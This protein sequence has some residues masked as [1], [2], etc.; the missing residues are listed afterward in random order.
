MAQDYFLSLENISKTFPG[1][2]AL[3][4]VQLHIRPGEVHALLGENG[5]GKST[6][7]K[8]M[9]GVYKPDEGGRMEICGEPV[10]FNDINES[11]QKGVSVIYQD[12]CL[13]PNLTVAEN[14]CIGKDISRKGWIQWKEYDQMAKETLKRLN[15]EIPIH[16]KLGN[17]SIARQ[18]LVAIARAIAFE[19]R[20]IVMD[21]P[22]ASLS[23]SEVE[24]LFEIIRKL[25]KDGISVLFI[26][27]KLDEVMAISDRMTVLR[28]G[29]FVG[30]K[31]V[32]EV[33][34]QEIIHMM[35]GRNIEYIKLNE[36]SNATERVV[37]EVS[38]ISKKGHFKDISFS[39][40]EGEILG[41]T[42]LVG[43]GRTEV[44]KSL[45]GLLPPDEGKIWLDGNLVQ[46]KGT[47]DAKRHG[48]S[49]V[50]EDRQTE[51][52]VMEFDVHDNVNLVN[53]ER[54]RSKLGF[55]NRKKLMSMTGD[56]MEQMDVRPRVPE[57]KVREFSG[58]NQ[59]KIVIGK[60][61]SSNPKLL[62]V[63][64]PTYGV[65]IGSKIEIHKLL[66]RLAA[67]G[68]AIIVVSSELQEVL[69]LTDRILV[70]RKGRLV[71][72]L[73]ANS[74]TQEKIMEYALPQG[75]REEIK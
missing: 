4:Q 46:L 9:S 67:E 38:H 2:K 27:H 6:L 39:V 21:E 69:T 16:E 36:T 49:F 23:R 19:A 32:S 59:Q 40:K 24:V 13:F 54:F 44:M 71:A 66:R 1:V 47:Q 37:A 31:P 60:W 29:T 20:L 51:S 64:E 58:G 56:M 7:I 28:D 11:I 52:L 75:K 3:D 22:T 57:R 34:E 61:L 33:T 73:H 43:A 30:S 53:Y 68:M 63:D 62:L 26:S 17:L 42:G 45:F 50:P 8:V 72:E 5:A 74:A 70:M 41:I 48:I 25:K 35:V 15:V 65:D 14:L 10:K 18:Q 12:L 55:L